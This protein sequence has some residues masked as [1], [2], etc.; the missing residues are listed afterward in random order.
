MIRLKRYILIL[1]AIILTVFALIM[2]RPV[3][4]PLVYAIILFLL[5]L[6]VHQRWLFWTKNRFGAVIL[7]LL[8]LLI[9]ISL[10]ILF[11]SLQI[12]E[13]A[14]NLPSIG[15]GLE[16]GIAQVILWISE[17]KLLRNVDFSNW[18]QENL[19]TIIEQPINWVT[20]GIS[21][22][23][24]TLSSL[25]I[26][27]IYVLFFLLYEKGIRR[28]VLMFSETSETNWRLI[29]TEIR[30]MIE[31]YLGG[32]IQVM[33]ILAVL[34][35]LGLWLIGVGYPV[36]WGV[37]ASVLALIPYLGTLIGGAFPLLYSI[38]VSDTWWQP[39]LVFIL[40]STIQF[41][42]GNF[43]TPKVVGDQVSLNPLIAIFALFVG[44][45]IWG[46]SGVVLAIPM[47][48]IFRIVCSHFE[49]MRPISFFMGPDISK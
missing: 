26:T 20:Y 3:L 41:I 35:S 32:M 15:E 6:P 48:A 49:S 23:T 43:I 21:E 28:S 5:L 19:T 16:E 29:L 13:V 11:F 37:L 7:T 9:P 17:N 34:N 14:Q 44:A 33:G 8:T 36:F 40:F 39:L 25:V 10:V 30:K 22:S 45:S 12:A 27:M 18:A 24:Q 42:E 2:A 38:A 1:T 46:L 4:V 31:K 47:A